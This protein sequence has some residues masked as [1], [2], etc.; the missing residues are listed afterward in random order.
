MGKGKRKLSEAQKAS[1]QNART[2]RSNPAAFA[3]MQAEKAAN[4]SPALDKEGAL[5]VAQDEGWII[6]MIPGTD[7]PRGV[8]NTG[9]IEGHKGSKLEPYRACSIASGV[10]PKNLGSYHGMWEAALEVAKHLYQH[11]PISR[12]LPR[13]L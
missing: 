11:A 7:L 8:Q 10:T 2:A 1:L 12:D 9:S 6:H 5:Q 3:R 13:P 4:L